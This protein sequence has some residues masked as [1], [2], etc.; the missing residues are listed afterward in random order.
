MRI[1]HNIHPQSK[2]S[3]IDRLLFAQQT[4]HKFLLSAIDGVFS[5]TSSMF[6]QIFSVSAGRHPNPE[7]KSPVTW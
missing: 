2:A 1:S 6:P 7:L 5:H 3:S 4:K